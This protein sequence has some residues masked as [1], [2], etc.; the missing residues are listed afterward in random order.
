MK[1]FIENLQR[2]EKFTKPDNMMSISLL[3]AESEFRTI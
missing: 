1:I 3:N 2:V